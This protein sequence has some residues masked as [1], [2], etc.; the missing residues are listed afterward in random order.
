MANY[1][2][3]QE[4]KVWFVPISETG[5]EEGLSLTASHAPNTQVPTGVGSGFHST[6]RGL[7]T[8]MAAEV[9]LPSTFSNNHECLFEHG[10]T[11]NGTWL[12]V[13]TENSLKYLYFRSG[14]GLNTVTTTN[15]DAIVARV[16][17]ST[18][19]E[20][21]N[22]S[23]TVV[24]EIDPLVGSLKLWIDNR[25]VINEVTS[26]K[27]SYINNNWS[28]GN[29]GGLGQGY[30][31]IAGRATADFADY[32][33]AWSGAI[34]SSLRV[35]TNQK[36]YSRNNHDVP[37][38]LDVENNLQFNQTF[39]DNTYSQKTLHE[40]TKFFEASNI[41]KANPADV[42][43][44]L[45]VYEENDFA[46]V[47]E[48]L[49]ELNSNNGLK[50]FDLYIQMPNDL[51][52]INKCVVKS[53]S[54]L[55]ERDK[56][57]RLQIQA[58]GSQL[59]RYGST[60]GAKR[61]SAFNSLTR[62][63]TK[64]HQ[65]FTD[66]LEASVDGTT[67][68]C[69]FN[70]SAELQNNIEWIENKTVNNSINIDN[71]NFGHFNLIDTTSTYTP[72]AAA[73]QNDSVGQYLGYPPTSPD[74][75][76]YIGSVT[77]AADRS[78]FDVDIDMNVPSGFT[79]SGEIY[80]KL[81]FDNNKITTQSLTKHIDNA[82]FAALNYENVS[83]NSFSSEGV[84]ARN[85]I[86]Y[87]A[88]GNNLPEVNGSTVTTF[89]FT[90]F[91]YRFNVV[92]NA[93]GS[94]KF[95]WDG[96][97][98]TSFPTTA[99][100]GDTFTINITAVPAEA[101]HLSIDGETGV[102]TFN[103]NGETTKSSYSYTVQAISI[104]GTILESTNYTISS[105]GSLSNSDIVATATYNG[106]VSGGTIYPQKAIVKDRKFSGSV[107]QYVTDSTSHKYVQT[108]KTGVPVVIKTGKNST[109]GFQFNIG[110]CTFTNRNTVAD[111]FTQS[112]DWKMNDAGSNTIS[113]II[114]INNA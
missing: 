34:N 58:Q 45:P 44:T 108:H 87:S 9:V 111:A 71:S 7:P 99:G 5:V 24:W 29:F 15:G 41:K 73:S 3:K 67:L 31:S 107:G 23:H 10:G 16:L 33:T 65:V 6:E 85:V 72:A 38:L 84:N 103:N 56:P 26:D 89:P 62:S 32:Q 35:Y 40:P 64:T 104:N 90:I 93:T 11:G 96:G 19:P 59:K 60:E 80:Y 17:V 52:Y 49:R 102:V 51:Y 22:T 109:T 78:Y 30:D 69:L 114:K 4:A 91:T 61:T 74:T 21:D 57:L 1:N 83:D 110:Q 54:F 37:I 86:D 76:F 55:V 92:N 50:Q 79:G 100:G 106:A 36:A 101:S 25:P 95:Y 113:S 43:F 82:N 75:D 94:T 53:G 12:G 13:V 68:D 70:V 112:F 97:N 20:F 105:T 48:C 77:W 14:H 66:H 98:S 39:T 46:P 28:G 42:S 2:L 27:S 18:I 88:L 8:T 47:Y 63:S 81:F